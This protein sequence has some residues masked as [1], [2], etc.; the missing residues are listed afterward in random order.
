MKKTLLAFFCILLVVCSYHAP[1]SVIAETGP[2]P[3]VAGR[4]AAPFGFWT[5]PAN[6]RVNVY[7]RTPDFSDSDAPAIMTAVQNWDVAAAENGSYVR[8]SFKGLTKETRLA[9][10][11]LTFV[12]GA[13]YSKKERHL[14]LLEAHSLKSDQLIDYAIV[15]VDFKVKNPQVLTNVVAHEIGHTLGL[16]DCYHCSNKST[17]MGLMKGA[18]ESNGIEG[19]TTCDKQAVGGAYRDLLAHGARAASAINLN[20]PVVEEGEEPEEDNTPVVR[21]P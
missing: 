10:G 8:F 9:K 3:C 7:L 12:R 13:V 5:W 21:K 17:A 2:T 15:A 19:P 18:D 14:A 11:D 1:R 4:T 16:L 6:S 20:R